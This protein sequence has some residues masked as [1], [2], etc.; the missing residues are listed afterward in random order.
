MGAFDTIGKEPYAQI[1]GQ[2]TWPYE[3]GV[4][5]IAMEETSIG[6]VNH[7]SNSASLYYSCI[8][9]IFYR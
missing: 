4:A 6:N 3:F 1:A 8:S 2:P 5:R 9:L 7:L